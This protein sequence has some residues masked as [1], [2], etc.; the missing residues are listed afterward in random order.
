MFIVGDEPEVVALTPTTLPF[1]F[2]QGVFL[3]NS[4]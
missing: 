3:N 1:S 4:Y 2:V